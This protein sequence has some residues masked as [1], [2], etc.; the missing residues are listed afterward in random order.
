M[1]YFRNGR[2]LDCITVPVL[3]LKYFR[4]AVQW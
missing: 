3:T 1:T 4:Q 2:L